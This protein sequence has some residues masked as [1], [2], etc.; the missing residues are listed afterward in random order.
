MKI[1]IL[2]LVLGL[3]IFATEAA[4]P[5][6]KFKTEKN[7]KKPALD[8]YRCDCTGKIWKQKAGTTKACPYCGP[9]MP[10]CGT[11]LNQ[12]NKV[13]HPSELALPN[14]I[15]PV[16]GGKINPSIFT[17]YKGHKIYFCCPSCIEQFKAEPQKYLKKIPKAPEQNINKICPVMGGK[18]NKNIHTNYKGNTIYFCCP[19]CIEVFQ[20]DPE[21]YMKI[22]EKN[23]KEQK[24]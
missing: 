22:L 24:K 11:L 13:I 3:N 10:D 23:K 5:V 9:A 8:K 18:T 15:C 20:K 16:M 6:F 14:K 21:K 12:N 17:E 4:K 1:A 7:Q 19:S 2:A